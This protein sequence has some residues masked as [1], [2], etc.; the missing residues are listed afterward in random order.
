MVALTAGGSEEAYTAYGYQNYL[1]RAFLTPLE[2]TARL[3]SM[4]FL[5][6]Y[7][8]FSAL[9]AEVWG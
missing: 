4:N 3:C 2:Q 9:K 1:L 7:V 6:P 5:P 8:L